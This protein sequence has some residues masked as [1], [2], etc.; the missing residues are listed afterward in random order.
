MSLELNQLET[1]SQKISDRIKA[2]FEEE[3]KLQNGENL[4]SKDLFD[5][6]Y[7]LI[8]ENYKLYL[9]ILHLKEKLG[10]RE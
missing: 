10:L 5:E 3:K 1:Q 9:R 2:V 7:K 4:T 8:T 6:R